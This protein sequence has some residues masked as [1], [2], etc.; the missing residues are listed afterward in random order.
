MSTG[1][2]ALGAWILPLILASCAAVRKSSANPYFVIARVSNIYYISIPL[3]V[4]TTVF[5]FFRV[6]ASIKQ[7][8]SAV[9]HFFFFIF[10]FIYFFFTS[11]LFRFACIVITVSDLHASSD[12]LDFV[13]MVQHYYSFRGTMSNI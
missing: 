5:F 3:I 6:C 2:P 13:L 8:R 7:I 12:I 4:S 9:F 11:V 10:L 1:W